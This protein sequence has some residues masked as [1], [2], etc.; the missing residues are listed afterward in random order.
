MNRCNFRGT[1][2]SPPPSPLPVHTA[3]I[4]CLPLCT[5]WNSLNGTHLPPAPPKNMDRKGM[6]KPR[7]MASRYSWMIDDAAMEK[8]AGTMLAKPRA[9]SN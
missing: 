1:V 4:H 8:N 2:P 9:P 3:H 6:Q 5:H 7:A